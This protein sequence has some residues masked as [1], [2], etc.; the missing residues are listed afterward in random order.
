MEKILLDYTEDSVITVY[1]HVSEDKSVYEGLS[2]VRSCF[3][4]LFASL[5]T[6]V[7]WERQLFMLRKVL[8]PRSS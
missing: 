8:P 1:N 3:E 6:P 7:A 2:G 4:G 5:A